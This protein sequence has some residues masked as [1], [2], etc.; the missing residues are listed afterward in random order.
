MEASCTTTI[1]SMMERHTHSL[2]DISSIN[3]ITLKL[4]RL[5]A[6]PELLDIEKREL[7]LSTQRKTKALISLSVVHY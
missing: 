5:E 4:T 3:G 2:P 7:Q 6:N 1:F